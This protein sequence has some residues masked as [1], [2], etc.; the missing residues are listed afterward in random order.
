MQNNI[1]GWSGQRAV[2]FTEEHRLLWRLLILLLA[3]AQIIQ[4]N[5]HDFL[6]LRDRREQ[7]NIVTNSFPFGRLHFGLDLTQWHIGLDEFDHVAGIIAQ[8]RQIYQTVAIF[9]QHTKT[10]G[11]VVFTLELNETHC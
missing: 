9:R 6:R 11:L 2:E 5:A 7:Q 3:M 4:A 8:C 1:A 10:R